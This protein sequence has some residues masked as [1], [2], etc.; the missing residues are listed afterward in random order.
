MSDREFLSE[1]EYLTPDEIRALLLRPDAQVYPAGKYPPS[2]EACGIYM[3]F[4]EDG[5]LLYV[6]KSVGVGYRN[7]QHYWAMKRGA[8]SPFVEYAFVPVQERL[9][10]A[11]ESAYIHALEPPE[12]KA[13]PPDGWRHH[14]ELVAM[15]QGAWGPKV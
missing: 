7:V 12:N 9:L 15:I 5:G 11:V 3:L 2:G 8:R 6:G 10:A 1:H 13:M 4:G 14:R